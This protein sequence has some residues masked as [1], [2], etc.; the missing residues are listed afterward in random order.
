MSGIPAMYLGMISSS[1]SSISTTKSSEA[2]AASAGVDAGTDVGSTGFAN[3]LSLERNPR[4]SSA[5]A[6]AV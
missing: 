1:S 2:F 3:G 6:R 5:G 4:F